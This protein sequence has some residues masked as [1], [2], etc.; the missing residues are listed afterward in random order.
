MTSIYAG[1][2]RGG[3][4]CTVQAGGAQEDAFLSL[5]TCRQVLFDGTACTCP[6]VPSCTHNLK[7]T[8]K[9]GEA[10]KSV[11]IYFYFFSPVSA[12][13]CVI[14]NAPLP[15]SSFFPAGQRAMGMRISSAIIRREPRERV[16]RKRALIDLAR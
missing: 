10:H 12:F 9:A 5:H 6:I 11:F 1:G 8:R 3:S 13:C 16:G 7:S 2:G 4:A 14:R 15:C